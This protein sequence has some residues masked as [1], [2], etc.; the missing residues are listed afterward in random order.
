MENDLESNPIII[1]DRE[2]EKH[3]FYGISHLKILRR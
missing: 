1:S 2:V 3:V